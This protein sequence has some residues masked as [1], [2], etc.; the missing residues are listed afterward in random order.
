MH[1]E[2]LSIGRIALAKMVCTEGRWTY[3]TKLVSIGMLVL[4]LL[5][6]TWQL[7]VGAWQ[8]EKDIDTL[9][10]AYAVWSESEL[11]DP[12]EVAHAVALSRRHSLGDA[13]LESQMA[14]HCLVMG[15]HYHA[16]LL[17][18]LALHNLSGLI[19]PLYERFSKTSLLIGHN[20][21]LALQEARAL[22]E[23]LEEV[24]AQGSLLYAYN[25]LRIALL[26]TDPI[27]YWEQLTTC[28]VLYPIFDKEGVS[29][30]DF[31]QEH[32]GSLS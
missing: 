2:R 28:Q 25:L 31:I 24:H 5:C 8:R 14:Q 9:R 32:Q 1:K 18:R 23:D 26:S 6:G 19:P 17:S 21:M 15:D 29:L 12:T 7:S 10:K 11:P 16:T 20:K 22:Q 13:Y 3:N 4:V 30:I 27:P